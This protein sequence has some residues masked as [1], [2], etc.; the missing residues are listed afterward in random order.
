MKTQKKKI[1]SLNLFFYLLVGI[2]ACFS[3]IYTMREYYNFTII[4]FE[5]L[6]SIFLITGLLIG[7]IFYI[8][9]RKNKEEINNIF[10]YFFS[11][12]LVYGSICCALFLYSNNFL[13]NEKEYKIISRILEK[14]EAYRSS[15]NYVITDIKGKER[16]INI[17][18]HTFKEIQNYNFVEITMKNGFWDLPI[19]LETKL[20]YK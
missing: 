3:F 15:P 16:E 18:N 5:F 19:I 17:H 13:S 11:K 1:K 14:H 6:L 12:I 7:F 9:E 2:I 8:S 4:K 20:I 10:N